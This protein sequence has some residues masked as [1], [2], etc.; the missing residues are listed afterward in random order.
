MHDQHVG[1]TLETHVL[2]ESGLEQ[3]LNCIAR[4]VLGEGIADLDGKVI[5]DRSRGDAL[6]A[7]DADILDEEVFDS[8]REG[9]W[10]QRGQEKRSD[11]FHADFRVNTG[12]A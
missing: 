4:T 11:F 5:E 7:I 8:L 1:I 6:Q 9:G 12:G 3:Y 10:Q 2:K